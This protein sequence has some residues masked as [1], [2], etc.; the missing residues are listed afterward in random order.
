MPVCQKIRKGGLDQYGAECFGRLTFCH[1][2]KK[3][4]TK[5]VNT[6]L[7]ELATNDCQ[8][9]LQYLRMDI[10]TFEELVSI[11]EPKIVRKTAKF[12]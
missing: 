12:R 9:R 11:I 10:A 8:R 1:I 2:Q 6:L 3:V 4:G 7:P 5:M